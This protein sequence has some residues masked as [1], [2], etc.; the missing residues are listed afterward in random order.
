MWQRR[1]TGSGALSGQ[2]LQGVHHLV[3]AAPGERPVGAGSAA[4]KRAVA[5]AP[6]GRLY[7]AMNTFRSDIQTAAAASG[8]PQTA[9]KDFALTAALAVA[10]QCQSVNPNS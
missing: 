1:V 10:D 2:G 8:S 5:E 4:L 3:P 6:S 9:E 7:R